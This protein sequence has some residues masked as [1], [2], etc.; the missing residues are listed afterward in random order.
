M[1]GMKCFF[2][3]PFISVTA[4]ATKAGVGP[5]QKVLQLMDELQSKIMAEGDAAQIA[6][7]E[8]VDW[9][10]KQAINTKHAIGDSEEQI[11]SL[12]SMI[13]SAQAYID[14]LQTE[15][16]GE[17]AQEPGLTGKISKLEKELGAATDIRT[18]EKADFD[19]LD[20]DLAETIDMLGRAEK[21]LAKHLGQAAATGALLQFTE[22]FQ[23]I[24]DASLTNI[25]D[26]HLLQSLL[27]KAEDESAGTSLL[28]QPQATTKAFETSSSP[29]VKTMADMR[30]KA[31]A[32]RAAAQKE[33]MNA[34][35]AFAM[36]EQSSKDELASLQA[37]LDTSKKRLALNNEKKATALGKMETA[38]KE[39]AASETY[40]SDTQQECMEKASDFETASAERT[41]EVKTLMMAKKI[42][43]NQGKPALVQ[44]PASFLQMK[45]KVNT[46][47]VT[48]ASP[49]YT[50][51]LAAANFLRNFDPDSWVLMQV[52]DKV[53]ADPFAKVKDMLYGMIEK[54]EKEQAAEAEHKAWCDKEMSKTAKQKKAKTSRLNEVT[55]RKEKAEAEITKLSEDLVTLQDDIQKMDEAVKESTKLRNEG[56]AEWAEESAEYK[57]GQEA[58][59]AAIKVLNN[60]YGSKK[61]SFLQS[62]QMQGSSGIVGLLEVAESDF[63]KSLAE[64]QAAEDAL[65][66]EYE[67]YIEDSKVS[68]ATM[69]QDQKNKNAEKSRL[70]A[71]IAEVSEDVGDSQKDL[72]AVLEYLDKIKTSCET[73]TPTHEERQARRAKEIE[74]LQNALG[75]LSGE[76]LGFLQKNTAGS[77]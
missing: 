14:Q 27:Q 68:R 45:T 20:K 51:Q 72:D 31:E 13:D 55:I 1:N 71:L 46:A 56:A 54:L 60:Y 12:Q 6:Y 40:L 43:M 33:E 52:S 64:G 19:A 41:E 76:D 25:Q 22:T 42:L 3:L 57:A 65:I 39:K 59:A 35:H 5:I 29:I 11:E 32:S 75:I 50:R 7:E 44:Q 61:D 77:P 73:K 74:G 30:E 26:K 9:C 8:F 67:K 48:K 17:G 38:T 4:T 47:A 28:E 62:R 69:L 10:Q 37:Q 2:L 18:K 36:Y 21:V 70:D 63:A 34:A 23:S 66:A 15:I 58:C 24:V 53:L 49:F 16:G